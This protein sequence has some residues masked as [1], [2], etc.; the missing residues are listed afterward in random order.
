M[1]NAQPASTAALFTNNSSY[2]AKNYN[3]FLVENI[4]IL[5][6][7]PFCK[8]IFVN[9]RLVVKQQKPL[10][11]FGRPLLTRAHIRLRKI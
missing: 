7:D 5:I 2:H 10:K 3:I 8:F 4:Q 11:L 1:S 6:I 9:T